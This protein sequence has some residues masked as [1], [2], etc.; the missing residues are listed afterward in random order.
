MVKKKFL[1]HIKSMGMAEWLFLHT[2]NNSVFTRMR[3]S[4]CPPSDAV[5]EVRRYRFS[6]TGSLDYLG[7]VSLPP[8]TLFL[9]QF[10]QGL[11]W[12]T[13]DGKELK[14]FLG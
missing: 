8:P 1:Q 4:W 6:Q 10:M 5:T 14:K 11:L 12:E 13:V 2:I 9:S 3:A 7:P